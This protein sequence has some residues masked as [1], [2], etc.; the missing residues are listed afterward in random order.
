MDSSRLSVSGKRPRDR[1]ALRVAVR[2]RP[3]IAREK[4]SRSV[5][6]ETG[7]G[8]MVVINPKKFKA[9]ADAVS[10]VCCRGEKSAS[11]RIVRRIRYQ[12]Y[13]MPLREVR[14]RCGVVEVR[15]Y[16]V[17]GHSIVTRMT[18]KAFNLSSITACA[19]VDALAPY[20]V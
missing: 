4:G 16:E 14:L 5:T 10:G 2:V 20:A 6:C 9:S 17:C 19:V 11:Q 15:T 3:L 18:A 1:N 13:C 12:L 8:Q 7:G